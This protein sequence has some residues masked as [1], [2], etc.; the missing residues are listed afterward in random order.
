MPVIIKFIIV[1][2][3]LGKKLNS[4]FV[5]LGMMLNS[6]GA[7]RGM[8]LW[9]LLQLMRPKLIF[10]FWSCLTCCVAS[11]HVLYEWNSD[12]YVWIFDARM[13]GGYTMLPRSGCIT[14]LRPKERKRPWQ[15]T[16]EFTLFRCVAG[17]FRLTCTKQTHGGY[18]PSIILHTHLTTRADASSFEIATDVRY[19]RVTADV[20]I[21]MLLYLQFSLDVEQEHM[22]NF[23]V[24][25]TDIYKHWMQHTRIGS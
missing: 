18:N 7:I 4:S 3:V 12:V 1:S 19:G 15:L 5:V 25:F 9:V 2:S 24:G 22:Q 10:L 21:F 8:I 13:L 14:L 11:L 17:T 23:W 20:L 6:C 16:Y